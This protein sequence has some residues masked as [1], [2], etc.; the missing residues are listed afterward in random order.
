MTGYG[1]NATNA[2]AA[3]AGSL[4]SAHER[5]ADGEAV[6]GVVQT[7][8][9]LGVTGL[10]IATHMPVS[11]VLGGG[12]LLGFGAEHIRQASS[13]ISAAHA[14]R[15]HSARVSATLDQRDAASAIP[16][17]AATHAA[18]KLAPKAPGNGVD[19]GRGFQNKTNRDAAQ[20][21]RKAK[22]H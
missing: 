14:L 1:A 22:G 3:T 8:L 20:A 7:A 15:E 16:A 4:A 12:S 9:G 11:G 18:A 21:A 6:T 19:H 5:A 13:E 10:G 2:F 17:I